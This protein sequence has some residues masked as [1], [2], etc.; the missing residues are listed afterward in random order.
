MLLQVP[1]CNRGDG[2]VL[3]RL[4]CNFLPMRRDPAYFLIV[5]G[6]GQHSPVSSGGQF[7]KLPITGFSSQT[8]QPRT[9]QTCQNSSAHLPNCSEH[10]QR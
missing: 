10:I 1:L 9:I 6:V 2:D 3:R 4:L 5:G 7:L 8:T